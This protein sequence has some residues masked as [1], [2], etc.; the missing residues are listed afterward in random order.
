MSSNLTITGPR[1]IKKDILRLRSKGK[2]Y[3]QIA[4]ELNCSKGTIAYHCN[5]DYQKKAKARVARNR[6]SNIKIILANKLWRFKRAK[7]PSTYSHEKVR[8]QSWYRVLKGKM[9]RFKYIDPKEKLVKIGNYKKN[10]G[11]KDV[12]DKIQTEDKKANCYLTGREIDLT[13]PAT[14]HLDHIVPRAKGGTNDLDNLQVACKEANQAKSNMLTGE[15]V[16]LCREVLEHH[17][18][19][20]TDK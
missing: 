6:K 9:V 10:Y 11:S 13:S 3:E 1:G 17:G 12:L 19:K 20:V 4:K 18:Y 16:E 8:A 14:Y 2:T 5:K 7:K 15:F